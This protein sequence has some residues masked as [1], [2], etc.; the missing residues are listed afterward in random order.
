MIRNFMFQKFKAQQLHKYAERQLLLK[1]FRNEW[2][3]IKPDFQILV[4]ELPTNPGIGNE[5]HLHQVKYKRSV[6]YFNA[7]YERVDEQDYVYIEPNRDGLLLTIERIN[8]RS[9]HAKTNH[10]RPNDA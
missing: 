4:P 3:Q 7:N 10:D 2:P 1:I 9:K 8:K 5:L 6:V